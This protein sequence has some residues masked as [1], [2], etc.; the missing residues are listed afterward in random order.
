MEDLNTCMQGLDITSKDAENLKDYKLPPDVIDTCSIALRLTPKCRISDCLDDYDVFPKLNFYFMVKTKNKGCM[1]KLHRIEDFLDASSSFLE[2]P[3]HETLV[4][5]VISTMK[6]VKGIYI[7]WCY[8]CDKNSIN[9]FHVPV[10]KKCCFDEPIEVEIVRFEISHGIWYRITSIS[11]IILK[12]RI[13]NSR[14]SS[15]N[16]KLEKLYRCP[17]T[18][19]PYIPC[20]ACETTE[21]KTKRCS[22]CLLA[23]YCSRKCQ[24]KDWK[25]HKA[26]CLTNSKLRAEAH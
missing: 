23:Q 24:K 21:V 22:R 14:I 12:E 18:G 25:K 1:Y 15:G 4:R 26:I 19:I 11:K 6:N 10:T 20:Y 13:D 7:S 16:I 5:N 9:I 2:R 3:P 8:L 17:K